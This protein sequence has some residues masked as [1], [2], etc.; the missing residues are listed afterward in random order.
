M[1]RAKAKTADVVAVA[2]ESVAATAIVAD[3]NMDDVARNEEVEKKTV[4]KKA[5]E[6]VETVEVVEVVKEVKVE[7]LQSSTEIEVVSLIPNVRYYDDFNGDYYKWD[8]VGQVEYMTFEEVNRMWKNSKGFFRN[9][10]LK[11]NDDR[12]IKKFGLDKMY[13]K[14]EF[15][16]NEKNYTDEKIS[17]VYEHLATASKELKFSI[18]NKI[19]SMVMSGKLTNIHVIKGLE[20]RLQIDLT[21]FI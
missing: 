11:P 7:P 10:W 6:I 13:D 2:E 1:A 4:A 3:E 18:C 19:K 9:M 16:M 12:V 5:K 15:L 14:Y 21:S 20:S 17:E 8:N